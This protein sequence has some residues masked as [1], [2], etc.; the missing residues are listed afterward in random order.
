MSLTSASACGKSI[1]HTIVRRSIRLIGWMLTDDDCEEDSRFCVTDWL[2]LF[3]TSASILR[4]VPLLVP[5]W[6]VAV[7]PQSPPNRA[8]FS[9]GLPT[10]LN[11]LRQF[12][13]CSSGCGACCEKMASA[14][15]MSIGAMSF[16]AAFANRP[17]VW[18]WCSSDI[19][20]CDDV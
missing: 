17:A 9:L 15:A 11:Q 19:F 4:S 18:R 14:A 5:L 12:C 20:N 10:Q 13:S 6:L 7:A 2:T 3:S 1:A 8:N 16:R